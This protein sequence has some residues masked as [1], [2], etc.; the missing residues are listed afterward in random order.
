MRTI[1]ARS[2]ADPRFYV[3]VL[4]AFGM[5]ALVLAA[6]GAYGVISYLVNERA[7][8]MGIRIALGARAVDIIKLILGTGILVTVL[9]LGL[10]LSLALALT[11][12]LAAMLFEVAPTDPATFAGVSVVLF[13][14]AV[15]A[16]YFPARRATKLDPVTSLRLD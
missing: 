13:L 6:L 3:V 12:F 15:V 11:R 8:E 5:V 9:G 16:L 10:G 1:I 7:K 4:G 2:V 14:S